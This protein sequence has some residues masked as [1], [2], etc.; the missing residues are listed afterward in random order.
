MIFMLFD[1]KRQFPIRMG[2]MYAIIALKKG[3]KQIIPVSSELEV[4][5][6]IERHGGIK[7][8]INEAR[9]YGNILRFQAKILI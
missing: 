2:I 8:M 4:I 3:G 1:D 5:Y 7:Q 9:F 6:I